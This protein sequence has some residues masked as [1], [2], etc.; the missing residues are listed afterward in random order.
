LPLSDV[1][2]AWP[3]TA[4]VWGLLRRLANGLGP[5]RGPIQGNRGVRRGM[6]HQANRGFL[7]PDTP[8]DPLV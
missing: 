8:R 3:L 2:V 1:R 7:A 4:A 6:P 5:I